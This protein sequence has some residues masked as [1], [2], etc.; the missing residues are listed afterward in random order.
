MGLIFKRI[1]YKTEA[2]GCLLHFIQTNDDAFYVSTFRK[3]LMDLLTQTNKQTTK[4]RWK[5]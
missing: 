3:Q 2:T 1:L 5:N 4:K